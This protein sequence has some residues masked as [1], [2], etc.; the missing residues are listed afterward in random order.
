MRLV[1]AVRAVRLAAA[2]ACL[3][4]AAPRATAGPATAP[5]APPGATLELGFEERA[6]TEYWLDVGDLRRPPS[7]ARHQWRFRTRL[8]AKVASERTDLAVGLDNESRKSALPRSA[9]TLDETIFETLYLEHRFPGGV[10]ARAGRQNLARG[11]GFLLMDGGP[12]DGSRAAYVNAL[13]L[14]WARGSRRVDLLLVSDPDRDQYLPP[15]HDRHKPLI[16]WDERAVG[17]YATDA[18]PAR[19]TLDIY[20][21][22]KSETGDGRASSNPAR[23]G[24]R[25]FHT[26]GTRALREFAGDWTLA[27]EFAGQLGRQEPGADV[28]AWGGQAWLRRSYPRL[29]DRPSFTLGGVVLSGDDPATAANEGWDPLFSRFPRWSELYAYSLAKERGAAYWTNLWMGF[30]EFSVAP[31]SPLELRFACRHL[32]AFHRFAGS[33]FVFSDGRR[34][35]ELFAARADVRLGGHW[36]AHALGE[37]MAPGGFYARDVAAW[38]ARAEV[39][40]AFAHTFGRAS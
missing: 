6:R 16:E 12:L 30:A 29:S 11:D 38:F 28:R 21:F 33:P 40:Y 19:T 39:S 20:W 27:F 17:L 18:G 10:S 35:G 25:R 3:T 23:Q 15:I 2:L 32:G 9:L 37:W 31:A 4:A 1:H 5:G 7:D 13:D 34:R 24:D 14:S 36:R 8:W 26:V 22:F